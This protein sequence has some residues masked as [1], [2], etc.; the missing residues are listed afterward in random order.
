MVAQVER[1][2]DSGD[3]ANHPGR[4]SPPKNA[5]RPETQVTVEKIRLLALSRRIRERFDGEER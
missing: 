3:P 4:T 1:T 5:V 2:D